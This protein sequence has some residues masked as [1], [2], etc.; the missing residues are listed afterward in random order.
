MA[1][2]VVDGFEAINVDQQHCHPLMAALT[3]FNCVFQPRIRQQ[4][5]GQPGQWVE[6]GQ[7]GQQ[8]F[9]LANLADVGEYPDIIA[10]HAGG[11][12]DCADGHQ[13]RV[14]FAAFAP[15]PDFSHP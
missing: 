3:A 14:K 2:A 9:R 5:V 12:L 8:R 4:A 11:I 13:L 6:M 10:G 1:Q 7:M 15:V